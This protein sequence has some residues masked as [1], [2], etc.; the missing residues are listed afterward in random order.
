MFWDCGIAEM[1]ITRRLHLTLKNVS[2]N[3]SI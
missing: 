2:D 3:V 1:G